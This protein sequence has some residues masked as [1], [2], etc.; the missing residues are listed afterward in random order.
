[1]ENAPAPNFIAFEHDPAVLDPA[2]AAA[3]VI[4]AWAL[5]D[6]SSD[7]DMFAPA[8]P[9]MQ[10][11]KGHSVHG[12]VHA[13]AKAMTR[14]IQGGRMSAYDITRQVQAWAARCDD[15]THGIIHSIMLPTPRGF[16]LADRGESVVG[17]A[18][19]PLKF[20]DIALRRAWELNPHG[21]AMNAGAPVPAESGG[22]GRQ[23][24]ILK[25]FSAWF[26]RR[27]ARVEA[28]REAKN[29]IETKCGQTQAG[30]H[31]IQTFKDWLE[32]LPE[33]LDDTLASTSHIEHFLAS[34]SPL[35]PADLEDAYDPPRKTLTDEHAAEQNGAGFGSL[36]DCMT[37]ML[38][39]ERPVARAAR[40]LDL[41]QHW[42]D[43]A[44]RK[45]SKTDTTKA[46]R[47]KLI[48]AVEMGDTHLT[49]ASSR[50]LMAGYANSAASKVRLELGGRIDAVESSVGALSTQLRTVD[51][52]MDS[53]KEE[54]LQAVGKGSKGGKGA[55]K[56]K[57]WQQR[58]QQQQ[59]QQQRWSQQPQ[60]Q[61]QRWSQ[62]PQQQPQAPQ[63][64]WQSTVPAPVAVL[65]QWEEAARV[66]GLRWTTSGAQLP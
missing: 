37:R 40:T 49:E 52:K 34:L 56:G 51:S 53:M 32:K 44:N 10:F 29:Q 36:T 61:Q 3:A 41:D 57:H 15:I 39:L 4:H 65:D 20:L 33:D 1:M 38:V 6:L 5:E 7:E 25:D 60:Q 48:G 24:A 42:V 22:A 66:L 16:S 9:T 58:P 11:V 59:Q 55:D 31:H 12:D 47:K 17:T 62:Q 45:L 27:F 2:A 19:E 64:S 26:C 43:F 50:A 30:E 28:A 14:F 18:A 8:E 54:L 35:V 46:G 21:G 63:S 23:A 13:F